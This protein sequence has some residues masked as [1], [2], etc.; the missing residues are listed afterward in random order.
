[1]KPF[2][3]PLTPLLLC[4]KFPDRV[5]ELVESMRELTHA[6]DEAA[7]GRIVPILIG[8]LARPRPKAALAWNQIGVAKLRQ[9]H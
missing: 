9:F 1:M 4:A 6:D 5:P 7:V 8:E 2:V 3:L